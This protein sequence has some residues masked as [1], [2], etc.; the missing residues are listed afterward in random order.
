MVDRL[1]ELTERVSSA[2]MNW[3]EIIDEINSEWQRA[4][5]TEQRVSL[6]AMFKAAMD[7]AETT[8]APQDLE[9]FK[10]AR[11][12]HY[13]TFIIEESLVGT[14]VCVETLFAVTE[15][16]IRAGRMSP[17]N[18]LHQTAL[19]GMAAPHMSRA[20]L[21]AQAAMPTLSANSKA[22][23]LA[24]I[25]RLTSAVIGTPWQDM[26]RAIKSVPDQNFTAQEW[27]KVV[28]FSIDQIALWQCEWLFSSAQ[29]PDTNAKNEA[30][31][32]GKLWEVFFNTLTE[33][34]PEVE[35]PLQ[36]KKNLLVA[37]K[38]L[39]RKIKHDDGSRGASFASGAMSNLAIRLHRIGFTNLASSLY[40]RALY[41]SGTVGRVG[42]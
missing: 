4:S 38:Q 22:E 10:E 41:P 21:E 13:K 8:I 7:I 18:A 39:E 3:R 28:N 12:R 34:V 1:L 37:Q 25:E 17:E 23:L 20:E 40:R 16:E 24:S 26:A 42:G 5:T 29:Q 32:W 31:G 14:N 9:K 19:N 30:E 33:M 2:M 36:R 11:A 6:L 27:E 35:G 15:R